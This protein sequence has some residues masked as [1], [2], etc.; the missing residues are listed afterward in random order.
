MSI[1]ARGECVTF[2]AS[3]IS[4]I[5]PTKN[6]ESFSLLIITKP[7]SGNLNNQCCLCFS[8]QMLKLSIYNIYIFSIT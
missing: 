4:T 5:F 1:I 2:N 7:K 3:A 6:S 8:V